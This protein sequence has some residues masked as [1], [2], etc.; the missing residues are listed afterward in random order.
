VIGVEYEAYPAAVTLFTVKLH[1]EFCAGSLLEV[2]VATPVDEVRACT[3][4]DCWTPAIVHVSFTVAPLMPTPA[5]FVTVT[6]ALQ[7]YCTLLPFPVLMGPVSVVFTVIGWG[8][9]GLRCRQHK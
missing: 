5:L 6:D 7:V 4:G 2:E 1:G 3:A 8:G 9:G